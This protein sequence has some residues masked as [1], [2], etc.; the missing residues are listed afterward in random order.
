MTLRE[1]L[2]TALAH[3][4]A[5]KLRSALAMLGII[6]GVGAVIAMLAIGAGGERQAMRMIEEMGV[7]NLLVRATKIAEADVPEVRKKSLGVSLRD[8][9]AIREAVPGVDV[10]VAR[11]DVQPYKIFTAAGKTESTVS[12][13]SF[14]QPELS[15]VRLS[16]GRFLD[17]LD[18]KTFAAVCVLGSGSRRDLFG[19]GPALGR[20]VKVNDVWLEV[21]GVLEP[22]RAAAPSAASGASGA[23]APAAGSAPA[24][25]RRIL[26]PVTTAMRKFDRP[27]TDAP[28]DE[29]VVRLS[30]TESPGGAA[31]NVRSLLDRLH[32]GAKDFEVV[33]PQELLEQSLR[34][35]R[36]FKIVMG[37]IAGI[38]LL[39][40]GIGIT[41][42]M[43]AS[44]MERIREIGVRRALGARR[45]DVM[46]QFVLE[47]FTLSSFGGL[48]GI[49]LGVGLARVVAAVAG[50]P[51]I[52]TAA[53]IVLSTGVSIAVGLVSGL[54]PASRAAKQDP[55][56]ALRYE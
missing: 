37:S 35:Q 54:Y 4:S 22:P 11:V 28:V 36:L 49:V 30:P 9:E 33:V 8:G 12:G 52:V 5:H 24:A 32:G 56:E 41:N 13:V 23:S 45:R 55:I 40:G 18:E 1:A 42:I 14:R 21:V 7:R 20:A 15:A 48:A 6:F 50:W 31:T 47:A 34:T 17:A 16:E 46:A 27:A 2:D 43:L 10:V 53:S 44:V 51:T 26:L 19:F 29:L 38:S 3:L 25:D 39:V